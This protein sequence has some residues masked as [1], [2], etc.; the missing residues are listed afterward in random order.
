[1]N[2]LLGLLFELKRIWIQLCLVE[3]AYFHGKQRLGWVFKEPLTIARAGIFISQIPFLTKRWKLLKI[4]VH[5]YTHIYRFKCH[6]SWWTWVNLLPLWFSIS[7]CS[8]SVHPLHPSVHHPTTSFLDMKI[9]WRGGR[10]VERKYIIELR[11]TGSFL[12]QMPIMYQPLLRTST[13]PHPF[14][15]HQGY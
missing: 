2:T 7:I 11:V 1:M 5:K 6:P 12:G 3:P 9:R 14:F 4:V 8:R 10:G 13:G 15:I